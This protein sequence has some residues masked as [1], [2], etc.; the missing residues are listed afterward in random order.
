LLTYKPTYHTHSP[1]H[2]PTHPPTRPPT[3]HA[4]LLFQRNA[5]A[6]SRLEKQA[7][8][9]EQGAKDVM[10]RRAHRAKLGGFTYFEVPVLLLEYLEYP[11]TYL[12]S[13][14]RVRVLRGKVRGLR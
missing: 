7:A 9:R 12:P 13:P 6:A 4:G 11:F 3:R 10:R 5:A 8:A 1:T 2:P 14:G